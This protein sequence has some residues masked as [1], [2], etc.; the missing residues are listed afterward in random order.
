MDCLFCFSESRIYSKLPVNRFNN[1]SFNFCSCNSCG[2]LFIDPIP[3]EDDLALMYPPSYQQGVSKQLDNLDFE[4]PGLR[5]SYG[6]IMPILKSRGT[7]A[8][9]VDFGCGNGKFVWNAVNNNVN[10]EGVEFFE[11]QVNHLRKNI[12][13]TK[14]YTVKEFIESEE[15]YDIIF[16]SN[17]VEHFT[18]PKKEL[19]QLMVKLSDGG[20]L[21]A[22]GPLEMNRSF[23]NYCKWKYFKLR[24]FFSSSYHTAFAPVHIFYSNYQNQLNL[25]ESI[26]LSKVEYQTKENAW[27][28][29]A[30]LAEI[31]SPGAVVK[32][33]I[34]MLSKMAG[35]FMSH[36]GNTFIYVGQK[37]ENYGK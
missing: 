11:E 22:E 18:N 16:L 26:G 24:K 23:V 29:P 5:H 31:K 12:P 14:F 37:G 10:I 7:S 6:R 33:V 36:Y 32:Y 17:V 19:Q 8:K 1:K 4:Q 21:V 3:S 13:E 28:Y 25:F 20:L 2:L 35:S 30:G 34:A 15:K 27:P 9:V